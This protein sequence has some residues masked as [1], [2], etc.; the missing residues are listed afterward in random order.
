[1]AQLLDVNGQPMEWDELN[2]LN[3]VWH[4]TYGAFVERGY[5]P[6]EAGRYANEAIR[7][8]RAGLALIR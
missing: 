2:V 8:L 1:M 6:M 5:P 7:E 3:T 4:N